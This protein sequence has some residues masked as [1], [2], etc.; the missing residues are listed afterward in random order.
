MVLHK[1]SP[2][3]EAWNEM[4]A[5]NPVLRRMGELR[6]AYDESENP[7]VASVRSVTE[8]I[9]TWFD[10]TETAQVTRL[11]KAMDPTFNRESFERELREYIVPEV[12]DAYLSADR[13]SLKA[14]CG[15]AVC[16]NSYE[17]GM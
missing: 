7:V 6:A 3:Q 2:R 13:E 14:W 1:D 5:S 12:V 10:E 15:E 4:K 17:N 9:G 11:I 8:T 16:D